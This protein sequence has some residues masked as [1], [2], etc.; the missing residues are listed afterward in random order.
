MKSMSNQGGDHQKRAPFSTAVNTVAQTWHKEPGKYRKSGYYLE[1]VEC[2]S[3]GC[4]R[5]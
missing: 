5:L 3:A 4:R 2:G 1:N